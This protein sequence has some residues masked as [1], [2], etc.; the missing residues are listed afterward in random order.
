VLFRVLSSYALITLSFV[1]VAGYSVYGQRQSARDTEQMRQGYIPLQLSLRDA[2]AAQNTYNS[3]LNHVTEAKNPAD[4][5][6]WFET[7]LTLGRPKMWAQIRS[8]IQRAFPLDQ[9]ALGDEL[10]REAEGI[11]QF[12]TADREIVSQLFHSLEHGDDQRAQELRDRLVTR[13]I[14][15]SIQL[16]NLEERVNLELDS[17]IDE[18]ARR[19]RGTMR[20]LFVWAVFTVLF[21]AG[22]ALYA[23][24]L[25]R[26]LVRVTERA[27]AVAAGDLT[28]R[29]VSASNDEI[30]EL[31]R[32]F[33][34]MVA[35]ISR[36]NRDLLETERLATIGKMAAQVTHEVRNPLSSIGLNLELLED[37][38]KSDEARSL[39]Q[40]ISREVRRLNEL[41]EQYLSVARRN[42]PR[43]ELED[44]ALVVREAAAFVE[45]D[46]QRHGIALVLDLPD[47]LPEIWMD[48]AQIKQVIHNLVRN[49]R[50]ATPSGGTVT[51]T[52]R[53]RQDGVELAVEDTGSGIAA[54][55][56]EHLFEPFFT[57]KSQGTGLGL[58]ISRHMVEGHRGVIRCEPNEPHGTRFS[59]ELPRD[60]RDIP[61]GPI[62]SVLDA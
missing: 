58:A 7:T 46:L 55:V 51:L 25:L 60:P 22:I 33:E 54:E 5:R 42:D 26:P 30:G 57:T 34:A 3:Q 13:G 23:R 59:I 12:L 35:A 45:P 17:L 10:L 52:A 29:P 44:F 15:A 18:A 14:Q 6:V 4:K 2:V 21:G 50:Q 48:E 32:T 38:L 56:R 62:P 28:A 9:R 39:H 53:A 24:R 1:A 11:E 43:F 37:E 49:A 8:A 47:D 41:T 40:A 27:K 20:V 19:E 36:A 16:R 31:A 61:R